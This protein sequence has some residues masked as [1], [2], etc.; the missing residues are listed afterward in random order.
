[1]PIN[2]DEEL[3]DFVVEIDILSDCKH[4][5][6]VGLYEAFLWD[7]KLHVS[8]RIAPNNGF[9]TLSNAVSHI[10]DIYRILCWRCSR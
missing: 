3:E 7:S 5:N 1:M 8:P 2:S 10:L 6:I 9:F 4:P